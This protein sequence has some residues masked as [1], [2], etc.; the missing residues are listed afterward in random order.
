M[1]LSRP[2]NLAFQLV[3]PEWQLL[4]TDADSDCEPSGAKRVLNE[5]QENQEPPHQSLNSIFR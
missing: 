2:P 1:D 4:V 3:P 5:D